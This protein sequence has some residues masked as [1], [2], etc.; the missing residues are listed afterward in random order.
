MNTQIDVV[1]NVYNIRYHWHYEYIYI[2][3]LKQLYAAIDSLL[4]WLGGLKYTFGDLYFSLQS[5]KTVNQTLQ[6]NFL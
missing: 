1:L 5:L 6:P 4:N 3:S 2:G